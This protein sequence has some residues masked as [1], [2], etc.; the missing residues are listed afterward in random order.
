MPSN[1]R[2]AG[3][4]KSC[5]AGT[6]YDVHSCQLSAISYQTGFFRWIGE[7]LAIKP[8]SIRL[9][10]AASAPISVESSRSTDR[11]P[12][13]EWRSIRAR[14]PNQE[15]CGGSARIPCRH[16]CAS[17]AILAAIDTAARRAWT[18]TPKISVFGKSAVFAYTL[19]ARRCDFCHAS[20]LRKSCIVGASTNSNCRSATC[21]T[22]WY[23]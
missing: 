9:I 18:V 14:W 2:H 22:L 6:P 10:S 1:P 13:R 19:S 12:Q 3:R 11:D 23:R 4:H 8:L 20:S 21:D 7:R 5:T 15:K 16:C 17:S